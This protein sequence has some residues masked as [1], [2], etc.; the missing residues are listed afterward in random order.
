MLAAQER[1]LGPE[2]HSSKHAQPFPTATEYDKDGQVVRR[3]I[4]HEKLAELETQIE[5]GKAE[6]V[7]VFSS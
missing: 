6:I 1:I 7:R 5:R 4:T 3:T 2:F